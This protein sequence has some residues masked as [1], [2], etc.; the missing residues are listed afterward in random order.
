MVLA[1]RNDEYRPPLERVTHRV[2]GQR[3][4][5]RAID[6]VF[7]CHPNSPTG[8]PGDLQQL[9]D[10]FQAAERGRI[11]VVLDESFID[12]CDALTCVPRLQAYPRLIILRSF[13][14]FYGMP[15]LRI[16]YSL[17]SRSFAAILKERQPPWSVNTVAQGAAEA[18]IADRRHARRCLVYVGQERA[19]MTKQLAALAPSGGAGL[20]T[21][22]L[23]RRGML[24]RDCSSVEGCGLGS[25][26]MAVR[27]KG[28]NDRLLAALA[29]VLEG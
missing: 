12:Y 10:L 20:R 17:S 3:S 4:G 8:R 5:P 18:A 14:K 29:Q 15:G 28:E 19:R 24:I 23:R 13:T 2:Q 7:I 9:E 27:T 16:G 21:A 22:A 26:R 11:W 1:S 6:A 25:I